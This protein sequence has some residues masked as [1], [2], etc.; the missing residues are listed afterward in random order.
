MAC[1]KAVMA[2]VV[3]LNQTQCSPIYQD[4]CRVRG[5]VITLALITGVEDG[6]TLPPLPRQL[7]RNRRSCVVVSWLLNQ[8]PRGALVLPS[9]ILSAEPGP[10]PSSTRSNSRNTIMPLAKT[11][12]P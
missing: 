1:P 9:R 5:Q 2:A 6:G 12:S 4:L 8:T 7:S 3:F 11:D 10:S